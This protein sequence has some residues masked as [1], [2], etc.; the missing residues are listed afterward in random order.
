[1]SVR[2]AFLAAMGALILAGTASASRPQRI[3]VH[4]ASAPPAPKSAF[5][6]IT[7]HDHLPGPKIVLAA[8]A[9]RVAV[10]HWNG[11]RPLLVA[12]TPTG[13]F[14]KS[15]AG[16]YGGTACFPNT[17]RASKRLNSGLTGDASG[18]ILFNGTFFDP[19]GTRL[20]VRYQDGRRSLIP[21]IWVD[22]PIRAGLFVFK[23]PSAQRRPGHRPLTLSLYSANG[24]RLTH[25][26]LSQR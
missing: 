10:I 6:T 5:A 11:A 15:L 12:P 9:R 14:C 2:I 26:T 21:I 1:V 19:R 18:P 13:G 4:F 7:R 23:I 16:P 20:E 17:A 25:A 22:A 3:D 24:A 8:R